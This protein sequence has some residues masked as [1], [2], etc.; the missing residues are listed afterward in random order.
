MLY[1]ICSSFISGWP[2]QERTVY[3]SFDKITLQKVVKTAQMWW[4]CEECWNQNG[5]TLGELEC[6]NHAV[7][8]DLKIEK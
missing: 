4:V 5:G 3:P 1:H 8:K 7:K 2:L 6:E